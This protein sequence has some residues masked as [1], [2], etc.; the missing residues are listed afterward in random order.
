MNNLF[1]LDNKFFTFMGRIGDLILLNIL[2]VICSIPLFTIGASTTALYYVTLK[3]VKNEE[4]YIIRSFF[5][6]FRL[7]LKQSIVIWL[8][9]LFVSVLLG[10][11]LYIMMHWDTNFKVVLTAVF[12]MLALLVAFIFVY[13]FPILSKFSNTVKQTFKN[14]FLMSIRHLPYTIAMILTSFLPIVLIAFVPVFVPIW[15][16]L[17]F[18]SIAYFNSNLFSKIFAHYIAP[19]ETEEEEATL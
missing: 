18:S 12:F 10:Y 19:E 1:N 4:S 6:S 2:W 8:I 5:K 14:S 15:L 16:L 3:M 13:I 11:D 9:L 17:G 7:N